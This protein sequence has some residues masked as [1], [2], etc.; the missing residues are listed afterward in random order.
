MDMIALGALSA[1][2]LG[3]ADF[4]SRFTSRRYGAAGGLLGVLLL[5]TLAISCYLAL[6]GFGG[7]WPLER[8]WLI[9]GY[10]VAMAAATLLLYEALALGPVTVAAP[11]VAAHPALIVVIAAMLGKPSTPLQWL[12][13]VATIAGAVV[14]A[15]YSPDDGGGSNV[16]PRFRRTAVLA[17]VACCCYAA[18]VILG[19]MAARTYGDLQ[20]VWAGRI[21]AILVLLPVFARG[22]CSG[23]RTAISSGPLLALLGLQGL[24]DIGGHLFL[25]AGSFAAQPHIVAVIASCFG[26]VT[27]L[28]GYLILRER[29][30]F[31]QWLGIAMV[32][33]GIAALSTFTPH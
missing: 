20:T 3:S 23:R 31:P 17:A 32:F 10:G 18:F 16:G 19:Q 5:S 13:I 11:I 28:L 12:A 14:S 30:S 22:R 9:A 15:R 33:A 21:I 26:A 6:T 25:F 1:L 4:V 27:T 2:S 7:P 8:A 29:V 24:L